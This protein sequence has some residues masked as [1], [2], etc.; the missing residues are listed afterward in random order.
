MDFDALCG[1][2]REFPGTRLI[3]AA[4]DAYALYDPRGDLPPERQQPWATVVTSNAHDA[5]SELDRPGVFRLNVGLTRDRYR[6]LINPL[7]DN[8][9]TALDVLLPHPVYGPQHWVCVLNPDRTWPLARKL[10]TEAHTFATRKHANA[11]R[12]RSSAHPGQ[13]GAE[14]EEQQGHRHRHQ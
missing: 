10:L 5:V 8:D 7:A 1:V 14:P 12:R 11:D 4:G 6:E 2:L 3:E 13:R 9:F